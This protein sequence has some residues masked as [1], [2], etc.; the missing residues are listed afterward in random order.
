[1]EPSSSP[2]ATS[3]SG[4]RP[5]LRRLGAPGAVALAAALITALRVRPSGWDS[6]YYEDGWLFLEHWG[7]QGAGSILRV[8]GGYLHLVPRLI[9]SVVYELAPVEDWGRAVT[10]AAC[11]VVGLLCA[12]I[13]S[14]S[15]GL[16]R[17]R[18]ARLALALAPALTPATGVQVLGNLNC[19]HTYCL[20]AMAVWVCAA[21]AGDARREPAR[22]GRRAALGVGTGTALVA[23]LL[24]LTE[25]QVLVLAPFVVWAAV[26]ARRSRDAAGLGLAAGW[27]VGA[28]A[29]CAAVLSQHRVQP[30]AH[31][32]STALDV[33]HGLLVNTVLAPVT[34]T[35][36]EADDGINTLGWAGLGLVLV[37]VAVV[38]VLAARRAA[39]GTGPRQRWAPVAWVV[40]AVVLWLLA[41]RSNGGVP[42]DPEHTPVPWRWGV[43][44]AI[45]V[46][47]AVVVALDRLD[48]RWLRAVGL[49]VLLAV[50]V[51]G[52]RA[53][54]VYRV[55]TVPWSTAV[56]QAR[57]EQCAGDATT[58][59][60][61]Q[62]PAPH[63]VK[64]SCERLAPH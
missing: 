50:A 17:H 24:A 44:G 58:A 14:V 49:M 29:Q 27:A 41:C 22:R 36:A 33:I 59:Q 51:A 54:M 55:G 52:F 64:I 15:G 8:Y 20:A 34:S 60:V 46:T 10:V 30:Y 3:P 16:V 18:S 45:L 1:M 19:L 35:Y 4:T 47:A 7:T 6:L 48:R 5:V 13:W 57:T 61:P 38:A 62:W 37:L 40:L 28:V 23:A 21:V 39:P 9:A 26:E 25:V 32:R 2:A 12:L 53:P 11:V 42:T 31:A 43:A 63:K 56:E